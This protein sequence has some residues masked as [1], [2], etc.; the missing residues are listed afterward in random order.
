[1]VTIGWKNQ[2][3]AISLGRFQKKRRITQETW[4]Q[5]Q[6]FLESGGFRFCSSKCGQTN[7]TPSHEESIYPYP[8][9]KR[10]QKYHIIP[11]FGEHHIVFRILEFRDELTQFGMVVYKRSLLVGFSHLQSVDST[12]R[13]TFPAK[14][15]H[16]HFG[17]F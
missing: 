6:D 10:F 1:M 5:I 9:S 11:I 15:W 3:F 2:T 13:R 8:I 7:D 12:K 17:A 16:R 14:Q 4:C